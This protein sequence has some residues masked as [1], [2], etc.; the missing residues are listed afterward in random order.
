MGTAEAQP[1][2]TAEAQPFIDAARCRLRELQSALVA[3]NSVHVTFA[4]QGGSIALGTGLAVDQWQAAFGARGDAA[5]LLLVAELERGVE[6]L[7]G[8][9]PRRVHIGRVSGADAS[10]TQ[11]MVWGANASNA[12]LQNGTRIQG[13]GQ[14][15]AMGVQKPGVFG[16]ITTPLCGPP[17]PSRR[18]VSPARTSRPR[19]EPGSGNPRPRQVERREPRVS[20]EAAAARAELARLQALQADGGGPSNLDTLIAECFEAV[21]I[22][23]DIEAAEAAEATPMPTAA[24]LMPP[25]PPPLR[26]RNARA[27]MT[28]AEKAHKYLQRAAKVALAIRKGEG[29]RAELWVRLGYLLR[30]ADTWTDKAREEEPLQHDYR[31]EPLT[32]TGVSADD[33]M[34]YIPYGIWDPIGPD[35]WVSRDG[36]YRWGE[37]HLWQDPLSPGQWIATSGIAWA[38]WHE[39]HDA[40]EVEG[41]VQ[42]S[43]DENGLAPWEGTFCN[44]RLCFTRLPRMP[45]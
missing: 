9:F 42:F 25:P 31:H 7:R 34:P 2:G 17:P 1:L 11:I 26:P 29:Q 30:E 43:S 20:Q 3:D 5:R 21:E 23:E 14:A 33:V 44:G 22:A 4:G 27:P 10:A 19:E 28:S 38:A 6:Q 39:D 32:L 24:E 8:E 37:L 41:D 35:H 16:I 13:S 18:C 36:E 12:D 45:M 40:H 15:A